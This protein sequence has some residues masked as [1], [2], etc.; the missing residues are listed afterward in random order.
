MNGGEDTQEISANDVAQPEKGRRE[1][2]GRKKL[3]REAIIMEWNGTWISCQRYSMR[4]GERKQLNY[5]FSLL[6]SL[7][8]QHTTYRPYIKTYPIYLYTDVCC[9]RRRHRVRAISVRRCPVCLFADTYYTSFATN[10]DNSTYRFLFFRLTSSIYLSRSVPISVRHAIS[11]NY[12]RHVSS[13]VSQRDCMQCDWNCFMFV[14]GFDLWI[15]F[16]KRL[17][18]SSACDC[19]FARWWLIG[20]NRDV[21][22]RCAIDVHVNSSSWE[23]DSESL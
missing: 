15:Y 11:R 7:S 12:W 6:S 4:R 3:Q 9:S 22:K 17:S 10:I 2:W 16:D 18:E 23:I 20:C 13:C 19:E 21:V 5:L 1:C 14:I 8:R